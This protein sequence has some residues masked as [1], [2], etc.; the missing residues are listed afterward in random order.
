MRVPQLKVA[1][2]LF[3][4]LAVGS[5]LAAQDAKVKEEKPGLFKKA[6]IT[7]EVATASAKAAVPKGTIESAEI[8]EEDGKLIYT[9][10]M[11]TAGKKGI[12]EVHVDA[13]TGKVT[14][15]HETPKQEKAEEA[16]DKAAKD[17]AAKDKSTKT[18]A[19]TPPAPTKRP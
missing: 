12:D 16:K 14:V 17:K 10:D 6:K 13:M 5:T 8:E 19:T 7:A 18:P 4:W 3:V 1:A 2:V 15:E 9:F 11:K